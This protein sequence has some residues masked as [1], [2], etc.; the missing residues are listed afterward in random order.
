MGTGVEYNQK[1]TRKIVKPTD[2]SQRESLPRTHAPPRRTTAHRARRLSEQIAIRIN[3]PL[4]PP[5]QETETAR[6]RRRTTKPSSLRCTIQGTAALGGGLA[7]GVLFYRNFSSTDPQAILG[8]APV[9]LEFPTIFV[10]VPLIVWT[11]ALL[12]IGLALLGSA[13][14]F[15]H[16][17]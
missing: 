16:S 7:L 4:C 12:L 5:A 13:I 10:F 14:Y 3:Q 11:V 6:Y 2:P 15:R 1:G 8:L 17:E 9:L